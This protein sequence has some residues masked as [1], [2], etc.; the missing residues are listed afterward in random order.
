VVIHRSTSRRIFRNDIARRPLSSRRDRLGQ[1][2]GEEVRFAPDS[3]L[4]G[5]GFEPS[6][7]LWLGA[8]TRPKTSM[9]GLVGVGGFKK[10]EFEGDSTTLAEV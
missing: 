9:S 6:V 3:L 5:R 2:L 4:E 1:F 10:G 7:P 8:F